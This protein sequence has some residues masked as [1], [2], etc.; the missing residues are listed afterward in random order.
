MSINTEC[1]Q[2]ETIISECAQ[3]RG[4]HHFREAIALIENNIGNIPPQ[5]QAAAW[6]EAFYAARAR[7]DTEQ[8]KKFILAIAEADPM[9]LS[10][11]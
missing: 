6:C 3:L 8:A 10:A 9:A 7:G 5:R 2:G 11:A 4:K 1:L